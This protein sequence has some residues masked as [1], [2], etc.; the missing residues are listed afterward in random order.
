LRVTNLGVNGT[1]SS[2]TMYVNGGSYF[3]GN[4]THNGIVYLANG[5]SYYLNNSGDARLRYVG[6][7]GLDPTSSY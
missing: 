7:G 5:T 4:T 6:I 1:N 2:Y 3:N